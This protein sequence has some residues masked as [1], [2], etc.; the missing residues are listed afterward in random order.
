MTKNKFS[1]LAMRTIMIG[2]WVGC[3]ALLFFIPVIISWWQP[4]KSITILVWAETLDQQIIA[5][6]EKETGIAVNIAYI[7]SN[8]EAYSKVLATRGEGYDLIMPTDYLVK[9]LINQQLI[10]PIDKSKLNFWSRL[11]PRLLNN[12]FDPQN[13][14]SIP[15]Y[16][17]VYGVGIN[18]DY[19]KEL[20]PASWD[21]LFNY[22]LGGGAVGMLEAPR[23]AILLTAQYLFGSISSL[24]P[25]QQQQITQTLIQ[26]KKQ[27]EAYIDADVRA[28]YLLV[29][30]TCPATVASSAFIAQILQDQD[31]F[32]FLVP[33]KGGFLLIDNL[34]ISQASKKDDLIYLFINYLFELENLRY[35]F[36][37][38]PF[39]PTTK[40][41]G[42]LMKENK[43][44]PSII[45]AHL[46]SS[47]PLEFFKDIIDDNEAN[48]IWFAVKTIE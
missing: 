31:I 37:Q 12:Y 41:L 25:E 8:E 27:V 43:M 13:N 33:E 1:S 16:W 23:E 2:F 39:M 9:R 6:F 15:Y 14:Y 18:K 24:K 46:D 17:E 32:D 29:S 10:K 48:K 47:L 36:N 22:P 44:H 5:R 42:K 38:Y 19:F 20:P 35:H 3:L 45:N 30:N 11:N 7:E 26:Q 34:V 4:G 40:D 21:L 28:N